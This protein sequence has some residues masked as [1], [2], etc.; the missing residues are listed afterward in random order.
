MANTI[1]QIKRS[2]S[3]AAPGSL[4]YG[5]LAYSFNSGQLFIGN[6]S[7]APISIGGNTFNQLINSATSANTSDSLVK[8]DGSGSFSATSIYAELFGNA[9]TATQWQTSRLIGV[10]GDATG[11][12]SIDGTANANVPLTLINTGVSA[13]TY[14]GATQIPTF[15]VNAKGL[16]T[17]AANVAVATTL[18]L[19]GDSGTDTIDLLTDTLT[20]EGGDGITTTANSLLDTV[21]FDLDNTVLRTTGNQTKT[22]NLT[23]NGDFNVTGN[24][25]F[26]GNTT[27][28]DVDHYRVSDP[29]IYL[30]ANNYVSDI[31]AIGF[32]G[33]YF[34][35]ASQLH[36]GLFRQPQSNT[37]Y[38]FTGVSEELSA[39]NDITP[40]ANGFTI[41]T[42]VS[43]ISSANVSNLMTAISPADGGTGLR[44]YS[45]GDLI[46]ASGETTLSKLSDVATGNVLISGGVGVAPSYG[47]VALDTHVSNILGI[48]NG[49]TNSSGIGGAGSI[50]YSNGTSYLFNTEGTSGQA[51]K[52]GG[53]GA[54][55]FGTLDLLG[56]GLGFTTPNANSAVF[57]SG[58][59]N[60]MS[61][62][63]TATDGQVLQFG[64]SSGVQ[65]GHLDG[66]GF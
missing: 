35:G 46:F 40:A 20:F 16:I 54:P 14:G 39:N 18:S 62:T 51:L 34:D 8:R 15:T 60:S 44:S 64:I 37:F 45:V 57:Y 42:L 9:A 13:T 30:A 48:S 1:I 59:G 50:A 24:T 41:A 23:I 27:F 3:T 61:Y 38:L 10:E 49:G 22:G 66:G 2:T 28:I 21:T 7:N 31:S 4:Q 6:G 56:G 33:N 65:F 32:V 52:S 43:N 12:I 63:N 58:S 29:L 25:I 26:S 17:A 5:E 36:T 55:T 47:K 53:N 19:A 11:Q